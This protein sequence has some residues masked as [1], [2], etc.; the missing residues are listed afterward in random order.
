MPWALYF[1][2]RTPG[3]YV[4]ESMLDP[5]MTLDAVRKGLIHEHVTSLFYWEAKSYFYE[6]QLVT[7][8]LY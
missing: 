2:E 7:L 3:T 4:I 5:K 1:G 6:A 8:L